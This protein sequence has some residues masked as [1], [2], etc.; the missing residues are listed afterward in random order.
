VKDET[1]GKIIAL[2]TLHD[3]L[4]AQEAFVEKKR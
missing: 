2:L 1:S 4:R 3:L